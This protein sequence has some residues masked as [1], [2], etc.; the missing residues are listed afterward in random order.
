MT[1]HTHRPAQIRV[2]IDSKSVPFGTG[3]VT[4]CP[5]RARSARSLRIQN[6]VQNAV[7]FVLAML[8]VAAFLGLLYGDIWVVGEHPR[9][10]VPLAVASV[11]VPAA[12]WAVVRGWQKR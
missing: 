3:V 2:F 5:R 12:A 1:H 11:I 8:A 6:L 9:W 4:S 10:V 7:Q